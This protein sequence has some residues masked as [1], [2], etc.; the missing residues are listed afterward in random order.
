MSRE[1]EL[2]LTTR[3]TDD[4]S[5]QLWRCPGCDNRYSVG[6]RCSTCVDCD[7]CTAAA[8]EDER[9][10]TVRGSTICGGCVSA[11]YSR[12]SDCGGWNRDG[13]DCGNHCSDDDDVAYLV[14]DYHYKPDPVFHG[15][16]PLF[17]GP[18]IEIQT[19]A[20]RAAK[21]AKIALSHLGDLGYL[22][23]D[24]SIGE[25]F[26]IVAHP[27]SYDWAIANFPWQLLTDL[28]AL[29]C[30]ATQSTGIHVHLSRAGFTSPCHTYRWMKFIYRNETHVTA[31]ARRSS[32][33]WAAFHDDDRRCVK[34]YAKG[35]RYG[36]RHRAIN[37]NNY[38]TFELRIFASSLEPQQVQAVLAFAAA[39]VEYTRDLTAHNIVRQGAWQWP[40][41]VTWLEDKPAYQPLRDQLEAL[42]CAC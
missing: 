1:T 5:V 33:E 17:L 21:S 27:M 3:D 25:G 9:V 28:A 12:C 41:F 38:A 31:V 7:R 16:G 15:A 20:H 32:E 23:E 24:S 11:F 8:P 18:E 4:R 30:A 6:T 36:E 35:H 29:G 10:Q 19:P 22:K 26:E 37:T 2:D 34:D 13:D 40:A 42:P 14:H 39:S